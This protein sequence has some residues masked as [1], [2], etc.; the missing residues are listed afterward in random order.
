MTANHSTKTSFYTTQTH[1]L[2]LTPVSQIS[3]VQNHYFTF[4]AALALG[5]LSLLL[6]VIC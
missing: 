2:S 3:T 1:D 6:L 4:P 5:A